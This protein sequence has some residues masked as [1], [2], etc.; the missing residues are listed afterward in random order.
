MRPRSLLLYAPPSLA[1][2]CFAAIF[3]DTRGA[4]LTDAER[5]NHFPASPLVALT[6]VIEGDLHLLRAGESLAQAQRRA[7]LPRLSLMAPQDG[8]TSS[9]S[10]GPLAAV[11]IGFYHDAWMKLTGG[12]EQVKAP[13]AVPAPVPT[14]APADVPQ[15]LAKACRAFGPAGD[16]AAGW[17]SFCALAAPHWADARGA[18]PWPDWSGALRLGDWSRSILTRAATSGRGRSLRALERRIKRWS[19]Q[20][21]QSLAF[22]RSFEELHR[23][24][25]QNHAAP[26]AQLA[27]EAGYA[28][29]SH[30]GRALRRATGFT[31]AQ[32]NRRIEQDEAFWCYRLLSQRF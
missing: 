24:S 29:Q 13:A 20:T 12:A 27:L 8:P 18:G 26:L 11:T 22:Y 9:W 19:G 30:M 4:D 21:R 1:S 2:C 3:R 14:D 16:P 5:V 15:W 6:Y 32:I 10:A 31:P 17:D 7:P 28:D 23:L 25:S